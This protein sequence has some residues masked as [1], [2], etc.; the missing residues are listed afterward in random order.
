MPFAY[1]KHQKMQTSFF[2][3]LNIMHKDIKFT[4]EKEQDQKLPFSICL[5]LKRKDYK[6]LPTLAY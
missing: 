6:R 5:L 4:I 3:F 1:S 2:I